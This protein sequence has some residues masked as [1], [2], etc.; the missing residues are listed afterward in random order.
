MAGSRKAL[1]C[2]P[3]VYASA[4]VATHRKHKSK[5][6]VTKTDLRCERVCTADS[7]R[8]HSR[9]LLHRELAALSHSTT[10]ARGPQ[11][12]SALDASEQPPAEVQV[13]ALKKPYACR[14]G[15]KVGTAGYLSCRQLQTTQS[16]SQATGRT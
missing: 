2:L 9:Y 10:A 3:G 14:N 1:L 5:P 12:G 15:L 13:L 6:Q 4:G 7:R 8:A 11:A 16:R